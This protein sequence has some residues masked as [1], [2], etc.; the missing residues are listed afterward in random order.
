MRGQGSREGHSYRFLHI[1]L[2]QHSFRLKG[3]FPDLPLATQD[4][5]KVNLLWHKFYMSQNPLFRFIKNNIPKADLLD[6]YL[7]NV[8]TWRRVVRKEKS[9]QPK[10]IRSSASQG[11][12]A[13]HCSVQTKARSIQKC[14]PSKIVRICHSMTNRITIAFYSELATPHLFDTKLRVSNLHMNLISAVSYWNLSWIIYEHILRQ[15]LLKNNNKGKDKITADCSVWQICRIPLPGCRR[16]AYRL[17][18][19]WN[20]KEEFG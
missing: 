16:S 18:Q 9:S 12:D 19:N 13:F 1:S 11:T 2:D 8:Y 5:F 3:K 20:P 4:Q 15:V 14:K 17:R 10:S 6:M 7:Y